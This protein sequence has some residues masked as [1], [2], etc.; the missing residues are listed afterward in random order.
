MGSQKGALRF[1]NPQQVIESG[2]SDLKIAPQGETVVA[3]ALRDVFVADLGRWES[4]EQDISNFYSQ[5]DLQD[6]FRYCENVDADIDLL[7][8]SKTFPHFAALEHTQIGDER[9]LHGRFLANVTDRV[10]STIK[11]ITD[12]QH[13]PATHVEAVRNIP[14]SNDI[15]I[16]SAKIVPKESRLKHEPDIV[17]KIPGWGEEQRVRV[18]GELKFPGTCDMHHKWGDVESQTTGSMHHKFGK[19]DFQHG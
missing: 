2:L 12:P 4:F 14:L 9:D 3:S 19:R 7:H 17:V 11:F 15:N 5:P 16:G 13:V 10:L 1:L 18:V 6:A 8:T